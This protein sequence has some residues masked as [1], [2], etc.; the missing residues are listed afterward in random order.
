MA[1]SAINS[2]PLTSG[3]PDGAIDDLKVE[4][5]FLSAHLDPAQ[6]EKRKRRHVRRRGVPCG[7][8]PFR[9]RLIW[10]LYLASISR[11]L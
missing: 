3:E 1:P 4:R 2:G 8:P 6:S 7:R 9:G 10:R 11:T 5:T